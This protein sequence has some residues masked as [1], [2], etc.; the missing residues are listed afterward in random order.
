MTVDLCRVCKVFG[1][2]LDAA[3][4]PW[5][6]R[7]KHAAMDARESGIAGFYGDPYDAMTA[8]LQGLNGGIELIGKF[9]VPCWLTPRPE[10]ADRRLVS[11][12]RMET[13]VFGD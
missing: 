8:E 10:V 3:D 4:D 13:I 12:E 11:K 2:A 6:I 5:A 9:P 1:V 7:L